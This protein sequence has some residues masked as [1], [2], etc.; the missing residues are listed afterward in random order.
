MK[1]SKV[2]PLKAIRRYCVNCCRGS[3]KEVRL[4]PDSEMCYLYPYR[5]GKNPN[6]K[7]IGGNGFKTAA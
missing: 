2:T 4:C 5:F 7:G 3:A 1:T 6:R